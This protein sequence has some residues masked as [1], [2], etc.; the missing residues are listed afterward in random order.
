MDSLEIRYE[1]HT[2][3][4]FGLLSSNPAYCQWLRREL[5]EM[6]SNHYTFYMLLELTILIKICPKIATTGK[7]SID[8]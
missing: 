6:A 4:T 5:N 8:S 2:I 1:S 7:Y 3:H